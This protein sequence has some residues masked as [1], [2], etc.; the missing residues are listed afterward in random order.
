[1]N[2]IKD[3]SEK[4]L[5][6]MTAFVPARFTASFIATDPNWGA[7]SEDSELWKEPIGVRTAL[8]ITTS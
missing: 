8:T 3:N 4:V 7:F 1:M 5:S 6:Y 2:K